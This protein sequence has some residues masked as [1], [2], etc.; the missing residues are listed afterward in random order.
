MKAMLSHVRRLEIQLRPKYERDLVHNP[1]ERLRIVVARL[2]RALNLATSRCA[3]IYRR[4]A[5]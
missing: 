1:R 2:D 4:M 3:D 5:V